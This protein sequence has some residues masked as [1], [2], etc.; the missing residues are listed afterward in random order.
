MLTG[1]PDYI[2]YDC[3]DPEYG[4]TYDVAIFWYRNEVSRFYVSLGCSLVDFGMAEDVEAGVTA[5]RSARFEHGEQG[6][7]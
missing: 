5:A 2:P 4:T 7:R 3:Y 1:T 6:G